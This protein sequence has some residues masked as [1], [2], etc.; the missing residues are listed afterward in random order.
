MKKIFLVGIVIFIVVAFCFI[1]FYISVSGKD[2]GKNKN[3]ITA[4]ISKIPPTQILIKEITSTQTPTPI[5]ISELEDYSTLVSTETHIE[6]PIEKTEDISSYDNNND[7]V[8][9][10]KDFTL[11]SEAQKALEGGYKKLDGNDKDGKACESLP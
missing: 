5:V 2:Y 10:C 6:I 9:T 3:N 7:G 8:V 1:P 4:T 11:Q